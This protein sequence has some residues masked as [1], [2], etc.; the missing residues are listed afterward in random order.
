MFYR[1][2][3]DPPHGGSCCWDPARIEVTSRSSSG[4]CQQKEP[5]LTRTPSDPIFDQSSR[6][7]TKGQVARRLSLLLV[8]SIIAVSLL[9]TVLRPLQ[10]SRH[11]PGTN[12]ES[13]FGTPTAGFRLLRHALTSL[14][15]VRWQGGGHGLMPRI[16]AQEQDGDQQPGA[17]T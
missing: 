12:L 11:T 3:L 8:D 10:P 6:L 9:V 13:A 5:L 15:Q 14:D 16:R 7:Q 4:P 17:L 1:Y 2:M